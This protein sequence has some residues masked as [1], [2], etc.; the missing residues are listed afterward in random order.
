MRGIAM[1]LIGLGIIFLHQQNKQ[2]MTK[3][4]H[5]GGATIHLLWFA[6]TVVCIVMGW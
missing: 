2:E 4:Q 5:K 1:A 6:A 3:K